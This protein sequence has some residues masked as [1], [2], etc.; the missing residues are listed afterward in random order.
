[1]ESNDTRSGAKGKGLIFWNEDISLRTKQTKKKE[2]KKKE[3][4]RR[5]KRIKAEESKLHLG[6]SK[7]GLLLGAF[8]AVVPMGSR[9]G[10]AGESCGSG[11]SVP[12]KERKSRDSLPI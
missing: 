2:K 7:W 10:R 6:F 8:E 4:S 12:Q 1:M 5:H 9:V 3:P 11:R